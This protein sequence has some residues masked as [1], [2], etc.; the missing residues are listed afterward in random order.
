MR[1]VGRRSSPPLP[2]YSPLDSGVSE[3]GRGG[4]AAAGDGTRAAAG[5]G[6]RAAAGDGTR[7]SAAAIALARAIAGVRAAS[8]RLDE[9]GH[10]G[11][12]DRGATVGGPGRG[13]GH[14]T[15]LRS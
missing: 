5:D 13:L 15:R 6:T 11:G 7:R 1:N 4:G 9:G 8:P 12:P 2:R 10:L 14:P 3:T